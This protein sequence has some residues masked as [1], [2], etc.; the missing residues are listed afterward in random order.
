MKAQNKQTQVEETPVVEQPVQF[1]I[2]DE[3]Q[4]TGNSMLN[5]VFKKIDDVCL[6]LADSLKA[7]AQR[8]L[9]D[10]FNKLLE[11]LKKTNS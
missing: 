4:K 5:R 11:T 7:D 1:N 8:T 3:F 6:T 9:N 2:V 10:E